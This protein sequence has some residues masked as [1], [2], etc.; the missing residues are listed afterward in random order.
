MPDENAVPNA[1]GVPSA[2]DVVETFRAALAA[3]LP[4][5]DL[6]GVELDDVGAATAMLS[7]PIDSSVLMALMTDLEDTFG[8]FIDEESAFAF[9]TIGDVADHIA[10]RVADKARRLGSP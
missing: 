3:H 9:T 8:I 5:E 1:P 4:T 10:R 6:A 7:L 2:H